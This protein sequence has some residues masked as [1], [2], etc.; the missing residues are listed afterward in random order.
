MRPQ[1]GSGRRSQI[2]AISCRHEGARQPLTNKG[3]ILPACRVQASAHKFKL[4]PAGMKEARP[5]LTNRAI[6]CRHA[7]ARQA[8]TNKGYL[9]PACW[10]QAGAHKYGTQLPVREWGI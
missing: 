8:L 6:P 2:W 1:E 9:L 3:Y 5:A 10:V 4:Y 7:G